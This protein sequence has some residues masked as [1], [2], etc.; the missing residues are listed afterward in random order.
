MATTTGSDISVVLSGGAYNLSPNQSLGG[1]PSVTP[2]TSD[3]LN[4]LFNDVTSEDNIYGIEDYRCIYYFNDGDTTIYTAKTFILSDFQSGATIQIGVSDYDESQRILVTGLPTGGSVTLSYDSNNFVLN[5]DSDISVMALSLQDSLNSLVDGDGESILQDC[6]VTAQ[7]IQT[8]I[9]FDVL[10]TGMD[11]SRSHPTIQVVSNDF[12][13]SV[14]VTTSKLRSGSPIN[15]IAPQIDS[16]TTPPGN[17]GFYA[18]NSDSPIS[19]PKLRTGDGFPL[20]IVRVIP[21][22]TSAKSNDGFSI[23]FQAESL[24]SGS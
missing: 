8:N 19:L 15:T 14:T 2:I 3:T 6:V 4:N 7:P 5:Y 23:R 24:T 12:T 17:V 20:W 9:F 11:G 10:Y 18:S 1:D 21:A 16:S 13:P 22:S